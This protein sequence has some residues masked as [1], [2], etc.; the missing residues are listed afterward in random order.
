MVGGRSWND[1]SKV[2]SRVK[3]FILSIASRIS[4]RRL[5]CLFQTWIRLFSTKGRYLGLMARRETI[6][7]AVAI[8]VTP[9]IRTE[10]SQFRNGVTGLKFRFLFRRILKIWS[11]EYISQIY[12]KR[13][14]SGRYPGVLLRVSSRRV[15]HAK[16][17]LQLPAGFVTRIG[18]FSNRFLDD[19]KLLLEFNY[20]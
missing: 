5:G 3:A 2:I 16:T 9:R 19:L 6:D 7:I 20:W 8:L 17:R 1:G 18:H 12:W 14:F 13:E 15:A 10:Y 4:W 11:R